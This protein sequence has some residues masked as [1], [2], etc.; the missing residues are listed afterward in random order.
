MSD[1]Q[2]QSQQ[3]QQQQQQPIS[4]PVGVVVRV[5]VGVLVQDP[6]QP[7][8]IFCGIRKQSH[9]A[10]SLALP[11]GHLELYE[12]WEMC[13][14]REVLEECN[15]VLSG[16]QATTTTTADDHTKERSGGGVTFAHVTNDPMPDEGKHY[17]TIFMTATCADTTSSSTSSQ[18]Q[19]PQQ[20]QTME[21]D[22]CEGWKSYS[23][24]ELKILRDQGRLFG[25]LQRLVDDSP[26]SVLEFLGIQ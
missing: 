23:W 6:L 26:P 3:Q 20:P 8:K 9:G 7:T 18:Q 12:T 22:K 24:E 5:G 16:S 2:Q 19:Q 11:G 10:G 4:P 15:L 13:A 25:P 14:R 21:P 17:V 1:L